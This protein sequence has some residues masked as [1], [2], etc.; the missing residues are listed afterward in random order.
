MT[1]I[2]VSCVTRT[3]QGSGWDDIVSVGKVYKYVESINNEIHGKRLSRR[4]IQKNI[5]K[6][7][8]YVESIPI[9][10]ND[11]TI[12]TETVHITLQ[13]LSRS[14]KQKKH[15]RTTNRRNPARSN[16]HIYT[17]KDMRA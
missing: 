10:G 5:A 8:K 6:N 12:S 3:N 7:H 2:E 11:D 14:K 9:H 1:Y 17:N 16:R 15:K 13:R 4:K